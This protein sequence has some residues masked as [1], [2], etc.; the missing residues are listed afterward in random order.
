M[1]LKRLIL[2]TSISVFLIGGISLL[3]FSFLYPPVANCYMVSTSD[4]RKLSPRVYVNP[5]MS[6]LNVR[7]LERS[8]PIARKRVIQLMGKLQGKPNVIASD[9]P[10]IARKY[11][12]PRIDAGLSHLT[13]VGAYVVIGPSGHNR[14]VIAHEIVHAELLA[15]VGWWQREFNVPT[16]FDE[17]LAMQVDHRHDYSDQAWIE[18]G[19]SKGKSLRSL[20]EIDTPEE[21]FTDQYWINYMSAR[22]EVKRWLDIVGYEGL[23][24]LIAQIKSGEN[25]RKS[26][27]TI[28]KHYL[29]S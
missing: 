12:S 16:W 28:E 3:A 21:F 15:R 7:K 20:S 25:F 14:D 18:Q 13:P 11:G 26:Y 1:K 27:L 29:Q 23:N 6:D 2:W 9:D 8:F 5:D 17:G 22:K 10:V 4:L 24:T 19:L